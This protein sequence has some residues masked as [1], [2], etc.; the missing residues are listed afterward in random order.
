MKSLVFQYSVFLVPLLAIETT[1]FL[2]ENSIRLNFISKASANRIV[3][4]TSLVG[5]I[6]LSRI[7]FFFNQYHSNFPKINELNEAIALVNAKSSVL[8]S[9]TIAPHLSKKKY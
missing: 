7:T 4:T 9:S 6:A 2:Q 8:T 3:I 1:Y 5:F